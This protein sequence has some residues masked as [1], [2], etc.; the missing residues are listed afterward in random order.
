MI[1]HEG[2]YIHDFPTLKDGKYSCSN[3]DKKYI[4][5]Q[6]LVRHLNYECGIE[7]QFSCSYCDLRFKHRFNL[8]RHIIRSHVK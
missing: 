8:K 3:C 1:I 2:F 5:K 7:P 4:R 6:D